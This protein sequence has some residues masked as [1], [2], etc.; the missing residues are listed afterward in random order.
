MTAVA[1]TRTGPDMSI[2]RSLAT[3]GSLA[4]ARSLAI[5]AVAAMVAQAAALGLAVTSVA[6]WPDDDAEVEPPP[7]PAFVVSA[8]SPMIADVATR[9]LSAARPGPAAGN[10]AETA[11]A[12]I[13]MSP[14]GDIASAAHVA[15]AVADG[16]RIGPLLFF[17]AVPNAVAGLI[18]ARWGLAGPMVSLGAATGG[19]D[20]AALLIDDGDA[21]EALVILAETTPDRAVALLVAA[22][23][24]ERDKASLEPRRDKGES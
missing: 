17:Q 10:P 9:C 4:T 18:A 2:A 8:F 3:A 5:D 13:V 22:V 1:D 23:A 7:L 14:L 15:G 6:S 11:T 20:L 21:D 19:M 16:T 12:I 24:P